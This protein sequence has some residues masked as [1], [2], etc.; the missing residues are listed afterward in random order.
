MENQ[1]PRPIGSAPTDRMEL[2]ELEARIREF[3]KSLAQSSGAPRS[4]MEPGEVEKTLRVALQALQSKNDF[5]VGQL[6]KWK[7]GLRNKKRPNYGEPA[8]VVGLLETPVMDT[9][10]TSG[11]AYFREPLD[12]QLGLLDR[13]GDLAV[14]YADRRRF[15]PYP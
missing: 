10:S 7:P 11:S 14:Y 2:S 5:K 8:I 9:S 15:E 6:V 12:M 3:A 4:Q 1:V 13:E